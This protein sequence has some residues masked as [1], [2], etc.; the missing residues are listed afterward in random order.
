[1]QEEENEVWCL[2]SH[3]CVSVVRGSVS[4][5]LIMDQLAIRKVA[6]GRSLRHSPKLHLLKVIRFPKETRKQKD[7]WLPKTLG[8][9]LM[10][11]QN[12]KL[13]PLVVLQN[14]FLFLI[15]WDYSMI[16]LSSPSLFSLQTLPDLSNTWPPFS[17][18]VEWSLHG[19]R[20]IQ[21]SSRSGDSK[22]CFWSS[23]CF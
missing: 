4:S 16:K 21:F 8:N 1:M 11:F 13:N 3:L 17:I 5:W 6:G 15:F 14:I 7:V 12:E 20:S 2:C 23:L 18:A 9:E 10:Q 19:T 22:I